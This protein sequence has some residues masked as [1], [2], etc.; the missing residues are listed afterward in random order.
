MGIGGEGM[1]RGLTA[2]HEDAVKLTE[3]SS[4]IRC[5]SV[6]LHFWCTFARLMNLITALLLHFD[7][8][9]FAAVFST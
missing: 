9:D 5:G 6:L 8:Y 1:E 2:L 7:F 4:L 3:M